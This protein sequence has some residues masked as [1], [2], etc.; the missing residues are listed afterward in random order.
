MNDT[1]A[2]HGV[3]VGIDGS[4]H[5]LGAMRLAAEEARLRGVRLTLLSV[6]S[7]S[8]D[9]VSEA[10]YGH[11]TVDEEGIRSRYLAVLEDAIEELGP[12]PGEVH[13]LA[14]R[15]EATHVLLKLSAD[16]ELIVVG[17]RGRGGIARRVLGSTSAG[18]PAHSD[19]P[20]IIVPASYTDAVADGAEQPGPEAPIAVGTDGSHHS[21]LAALE[22]A[23][24]AS[25]R[26]A[27]L[28]LVSALPPL[29]PDFHWTRHPKHHEA[30]TQEL[31]DRLTTDAAW[32]SR[33]YPG[34]ESHE[35]I[36]SGNA[37]DVLIDVSSRSQLTVVGRRGRGGFLGL[38]LGST[39]NTVMHHAH[40]P[41]MIVP[42]REDPRIDDH[43]DAAQW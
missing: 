21:M 37:G 35:M 1:T 38:L 4:A 22:A 12:F 8:A 2:E 43:P 6:Y 27:P 33:H 34:L 32:L 40:G 23:R 14:Q 5:S 29:T 24:M 36:M 13:T 3:I 25:E 18:L 30:A 41:L 20:V 28:H 11:A 42:D 7:M 9:V 39:S 19:A 15:G 10:S 26:G 16:A 31:Q 17:S